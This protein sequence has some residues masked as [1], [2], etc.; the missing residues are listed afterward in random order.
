MCIRDSY[1]EASLVAG[2]DNWSTNIG[3]L[4]DERLNET[5]PYVWA[6]SSTYG[7]A[8]G[9]EGN[10]LLGAS[11]GNDV[12]GYHSG[13][14]IQKPHVYMVAADF[15]NGKI[16][17]GVDGVW[18]GNPSTGASPAATNLLSVA[19]N[20]VYRPAVGGYYGTTEIHVNFGQRPWHYT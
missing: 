12:S 4:G 8:I 2:S 3:W 19:D 7:W 18:V 9:N 1:Y 13:G 10:L 14:S 11:S 6:N 20:L 5:D 15:D 17:F 16:W